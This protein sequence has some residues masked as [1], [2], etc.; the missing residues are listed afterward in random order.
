MRTGANLRRLA[1]L[2]R[3]K[4]GAAKSG[5]QDGTARQES[6]RHRHAPPISRGGTGM[7][8]AKDGTGAMRIRYREART[9][10][11]RLCRLP[12]EEPEAFR[13]KVRQLRAHFEAFNRDCADLCQWLMG[14]RKRFGDEERPATFG[15]FGDFFLEPEIPGVEADEKERD[16]WRLEAF[17]AVANAAGKA[18]LSEVAIPDALT[19]AIEEVREGG[20]QCDARNVNAQRL[21]SRLR[22]VDPGQRLVLLKSAAEW[23]VSRYKRGVEN[24]ERQHEAWE[25]EK[26][27]WEAAHPRLTPEIRERFTEVFRALKDPETGGGITRKN[28]KI[29]TWERLKQNDDNCLY[30]GER[31]H[32][33]LCN[34]YEQFVRTQEETEK[35]RFGEHA[36]YSNAHWFAEWCRTQRISKPELA[37]QS[38]HFDQALA[39]A[40]S[41]RREEA[42]R[43][44]SQLPGGQSVPATEIARHFKRNWQAYLKALN[45]NA[46]TAVAGGRLQHCQKKGRQNYEKSECRFNRHTALCMAYK[47]ALLQLPDAMRELEGEYRE[48]RRLYLAGPRKPTFKY[49]SA[50]EL[51]MPKVF[52]AGFHEANLERSVLRL[53]LEGVDGGWVEFGFIPWPRGYRPSRMEVKITSVHVNFVGVRARAGLRF[54]VPHRRS[55]FG[56]RQE[57]IND[58]RSRVYPRETQDEAFLRA[59]REGLLKGYSGD[60]DRLRV[61]AVDVGEEAAGASVFEGRRHVTD[62][63][64]EIL[65][66]N[67]LYSARPAELTRDKRGRPVSVKIDKDDPRGLTLRHVGRHLERVAER[68]AAIAA[69][70]AEEGEA[71]PKPLAGDLRSL[72]RHLAWMIRD[73]ARVNAKQIVEA[74]EV[75]ECEVIVFESRRGVRAPGYDK[76]SEDDSR[77]KRSIA[78]F[79]FGQV[80]GRVVEKAVERGMRVVTAPTY[81][82]SQVCWMCGHEQMN[83]GLLKKRKEKRRFECQCGRPD[84]QDRRSPPPDAAC[85]CKAALNSE[86]NA[87]RVLARVFWGEIRL[88]RRECVSKSGG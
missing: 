77:K 66:I 20:P 25:A 35:G 87:A 14:V 41:R 71:A 23:V 73:W 85:A 30:A 44:K 62:V 51:P 3:E 11:R 65:K 2:V 61:L 45:I 67:R 53:R 52:G 27:E 76:V 15:T 4:G 8:R 78:M 58:L 80:R 37:F 82:S 59:A 69:H 16:R 10:V 60:V 21:F 36:F 56:M 33:P 24:W 72:K 46:S 26:A 50:R 43:K 55:R 49:P 70:R 48:W 31:G 83:K 17:D 9:L 63:S 57:A 19:R 40:D 42:A 38:P 13:R 6:T 79:A 54:E 29:C 74:A 7:R 34:L 88:P 1:A 86:A 12:G 32:G 18:A 47:G 64:L 39:A 5:C 28:P 22:G 68:D 84:S 81:K 75:H